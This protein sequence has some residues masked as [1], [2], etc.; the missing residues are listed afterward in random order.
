MIVH[1]FLGYQAGQILMCYTGHWQRISRFLVWGVL[2]GLLALL[3][4]Q[5]NLNEG[6]IPINKNLWY[7]HY[8]KIYLMVSKDVYIFVSTLINHCI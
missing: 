4:C 3:L 1:V 7:G 2:T 6:W 5:A 8:K